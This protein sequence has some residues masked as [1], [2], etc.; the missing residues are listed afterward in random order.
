MNLTLHVG[1]GTFQPVKASEVTNHVMHCEHF[2][3]SKKAIKL[4]IENQG[5][6]IAVGTT[7]VRTLESLLLAGCKDFR[8]QF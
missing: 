4:L 1:A 7:S 2:R 5:N 8:T 6:I 3:V